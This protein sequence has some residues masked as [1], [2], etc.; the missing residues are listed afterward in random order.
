MHNV[1]ALF[2][3][4]DSVYKEMG[5]DCWDID[6][7]AT[8]YDLNNSIVGHPPCRAWGRLSYFA[9][10][11]EGEKELAI[12]CVEKIREL[13]GVL[14]HPR[15]SKLWDHMGLPLNSNDIDE[16]GGYSISVNQSWFGHWAEKKTLLYIVGCPI[17]ELPE[18]PISFDAI[19]YVIS[20]NRGDTTKKEVPRHMRESTPIKFAE[21]LVEVAKICFNNKN[22]GGL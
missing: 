16:Y 20:T 18:I 2:V 8:N 14:E 1:S 12:W 19:Q 10:P 21:W 7:D 3:R 11:R 13:G 9:R 4:R 22:R 6:R 15:A 5:I 17:T